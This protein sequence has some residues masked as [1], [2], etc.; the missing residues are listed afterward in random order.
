MVNDQQVRRLWRLSGLGMSLEVGAAEA[1]MA[2]AFIP[3]TK[4]EATIF[5]QL[6]SARYERGSIILTF[7]KATANG[8]FRPPGTAGDS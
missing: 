2:I 6:I 3:K 7:N 5:F 1:G 4:P 8:A